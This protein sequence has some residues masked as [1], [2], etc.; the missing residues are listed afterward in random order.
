MKILMVCLGNICRSPI[1]EGVLANKAAKAGLLWQIDSAGTNG[2]HTGQ[3]PHHFSQ[4]VSRQNGIDISLQKSRLFKADDFEK[5]DKIY[6]MAAEVIEEIKYIAK[7]KFDANKVD[8]LMNELHPGSNKDIIDPWYG[9]E[10]GYH[11]VYQLIDA[12]CDSLVRRTVKLQT[13]LNN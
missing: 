11:Q 1:A 9:S 8:L 10:D 2:F 12:A 6:A 7:D 13:Q 5:Y 3:P 4:K